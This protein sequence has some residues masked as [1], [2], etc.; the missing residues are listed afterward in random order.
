MAFKTLRLNMPTLDRLEVLEIKA[1]LDA[2][3]DSWRHYNLDRVKRNGRLR[4]KYPCI[5]WKWSLESPPPVDG[6]IPE[7][8]F[9]PSMPFYG[10]EYL[11]WIPKPPMWL[12][13]VVELDAREAWRNYWLDYPEKHPTI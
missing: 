11:T 1:M 3:D 12:K 8:L 10:V 6:M 13:E 4:T 5:C 9:E 7:F 2:V